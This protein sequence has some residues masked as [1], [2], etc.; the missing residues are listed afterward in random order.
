MLDV[1]LTCAAIGG[2]ILIVQLVLNLLGFGHHDAGGF[3]DH[4]AGLDDHQ[5]THETQGHAFLGILSFRTIVAADLVPGA[6]RN[7]DGA[8]ATPGRTERALVTDTTARSVERSLSGPGVGDG[9]QDLDG[10][11]AAVRQ[12]VGGGLADLL[13]HDRGTEG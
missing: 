1:Y 9:V 7:P 6:L 10:G 11:G 4:D 8:A 2:T 12:R 3:G 13:A 5:A